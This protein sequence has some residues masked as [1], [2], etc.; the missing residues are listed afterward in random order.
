MTATDEL[1]R[2]LDERGVADGLEHD[3]YVEWI[4]A[5][6]RMAAAFESAGDHG[7]VMVHAHMDPETAI[8][9]TLGPDPCKIKPI[10]GLARDGI[11]R[12]SMPGRDGLVG[13]LRSLAEGV[14]DAVRLGAVTGEG[15]DRAWCRELYDRYSA[16]LAELGFGEEGR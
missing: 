14:L 16:E 6:G 1:R 3:L 5:G 9:A 8:L 10:E 12:E 11:Y 15:I 13:R 7:T 2:L 4:D